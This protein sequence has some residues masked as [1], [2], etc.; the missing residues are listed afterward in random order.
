LSSSQPAS[1]MQ[2]PSDGSSQRRTRSG[3]DRI[4]KV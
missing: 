2:K 4:L 1:R 3:S